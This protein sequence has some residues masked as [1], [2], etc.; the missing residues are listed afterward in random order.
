MAF[1]EDLA[2]AHQAREGWYPGSLSQANNNPGNLRFQ[3]YQHSLYG[4]TPGL[5]NFASFPTYQA[6]FRALIDDL[7]AKITGHS[8]HIDYEKVPKPTFLD[9]VKV[10]APAEDSN[11]PTSYAQFLVKRLSNYNIRLDTPLSVL[12]SLVNGEISAVAAE[13]TMNITPQTRLQN[14]IRRLARTTNAGARSIIS[15]TIQQL[16]KRIGS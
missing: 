1:L 12:A 8:T 15:F 4:A 9:Y 5:K 6:G 14:L 10:Y 2:A 13:P 16:K 11:D 7:R 3:P